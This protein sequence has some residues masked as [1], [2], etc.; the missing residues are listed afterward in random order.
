MTKQ[1]V[2]EYDTIV[3][4]RTSA[5][6]QWLPTYPAPPVISMPAIVLG[7]YSE[8]YVELMAP[9]FLPEH[10]AGQ[11]ERDA[12]IEE[13]HRSLLQGASET[14]R[15]S[16]AD[17]QWPNNARGTGGTFKIADEVSEREDTLEQLRRDL[18]RLLQSPK[19]A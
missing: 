4:G 6:A 3:S 15:P 1:E 14:H 13:L 10:F 5:L 7:K 12:L 8:N 18:D 9:C 2:V 17:D 16:Q 11:V 19:G